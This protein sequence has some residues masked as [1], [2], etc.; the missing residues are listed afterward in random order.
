MGGILILEQG[1]EKMIIPSAE[2]CKFPLGKGARVL[3]SMKTPSGHLALK[4]DGYG[5][6]TED[7]GSM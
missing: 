2:M 6:A 7:E 4:A 5:A 3:D 1:H